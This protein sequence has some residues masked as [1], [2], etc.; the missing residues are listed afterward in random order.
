MMAFTNKNSVGFHLRRPTEF[1]KINTFQY[2]HLE[3]ELEF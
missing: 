3:T 1:S 2:L